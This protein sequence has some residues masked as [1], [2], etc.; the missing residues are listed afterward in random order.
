AFQTLKT[1][2][3]TAP[4]FVQPDVSKPFEVYCDASGIGL[5]CVLMQE[6]RVVAYASRQLKKHEEHYPTH[7]L[8]LAAVSELNMR[9]RRWLELIKDYD[10]EIHYHPRKANLVAD[11]LSQKAHCNCVTLRPSEESL[12]WEMEKLNLEIVQQGTIA[13]LQLD[14]SIKD[15][16]VQAQQLD[17]GLEHLRRRISKGEELPFKLDETNVLWFKGRLV[18]PK[19]P[20]LRRKIMEEAHTSRFTIHPGSTKMYQDLKQQFWW[21]RMK[22]EIGKLVSECDKSLE[23]APFEA[24]Y[25]RRCRTPLNWSE[26]GERVIFGSELVAAAEKQVRFIQAKLKAAQPRQKAYADKRR[27]PLTFRAGEFVYL[28]RCGPVAYR[29]KLPPHLSAVHN[30]FHISQLK[31]CLR[32]PSEEEDHTDLQ[33]EPN[34]AYQEYPSKILDMKERATQRRVIK[35]YKIQW[36]NHT[37]E[38]ATW[39]SEQFLQSKYP[40]FWEWVQKGSVR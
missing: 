36:R 6:R 2:L 35:F 29:L 18:V 34:L 38:E 28:K 25:G 40:E 22:R 26:F 8:E 21:T 15:Q 24:L 39:E 7:D 14:M 37:P 11:A 9:Q 33:L 32:V 1:L 23:M 27:R 4:A 10:L 31:K 5:G 20:E 16:I 12:C 13:A 30:V 17:K 3:T 19:N